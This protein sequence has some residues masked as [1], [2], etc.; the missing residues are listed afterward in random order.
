MWSVRGKEGHIQRRERGIK[1]RLER[2]PEWKKIFANHISDKRL[3]PRK[4]K[5]LLQRNNRNKITQLKMG[6]KFEWIFL[7]R[8][9]V[10]DQ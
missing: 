2:Q 5:E 3:T 7:Q 9:C 6:N 8:R 4:Y 10:N 1:N